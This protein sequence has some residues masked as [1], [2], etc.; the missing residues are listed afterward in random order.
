MAA[1][2]IETGGAVTVAEEAERHARQNMFTHLK[3]AVKRY[4]DTEFAEAARWLSAAKD[5]TD[6]MKR[7]RSLMRGTWQDNVAMT[8][9][10][11]TGLA[12]GVLGGRL[13]PAKIVGPVPALSI[14]GVL[15]F[16]GGLLMPGTMTMRNVVG[17]GGA[18]FTAGSILG[19]S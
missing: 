8:V 2:K 16:V 12:L 14:L 6:L 15:G 5:E 1:A 13:V 11:L 19:A 9:S 17:L 3:E 4:R 18:L 10:S 7:T